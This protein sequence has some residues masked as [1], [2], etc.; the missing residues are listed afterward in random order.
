M[1]TNGIYKKFTCLSFIFLIKS[2]F[3]IGHIDSVTFN[4]TQIQISG[5]AC[6]N[7]APDLN[8]SIQ[9]KVGSSN[10]FSAT[11]SL[12][13]E[14]D[15][16]IACN[17]SHS[18]HGF[19][20]TINPSLDNTYKEVTLVIN[21]SAA[22]AEVITRPNNK[23]FFNKH[24]FVFPAFAADIVGRDL[25]YP[26][27]GFY[28][29]V[30][31]S[32]IDGT[33]WEV[34]N[35]PVVPQHNSWSDFISR[36]RVW[37][38]V[39]AKVPLVGDIK[40]CFKPDKCKAFPNPVFGGT[41]NETYELLDHPSNV[42]KLNRRE[43]ALWRAYQIYAS[44]NVRYTY[45]SNYTPAV[46]E[47]R[48]ANTNALMRAAVEGVY[49]CDTYVLDALAITVRPALN[50]KISIWRDKNLP[51]KIDTHYH[52]GWINSFSNIVLQRTPENVYNALRFSPNF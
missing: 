4:G 38:T 41:T 20:L 8:S 1:G 47:I 22:A 25:D 2:S 52:P 30:G 24:D 17:S 31:L 42:D 27:V 15:V 18:N 45:S 39:K 16:A 33:V 10:S 11:A 14:H 43:A 36:T 29:H 44:P 48:D 26:V 28:G 19:N 49:R 7:S 6:D 21:Q 34:L 32:N 37:D 9:I 50:N 40:T 35:N 13:R 51:Y 46:P 12:P 23:F 5:W 3:A